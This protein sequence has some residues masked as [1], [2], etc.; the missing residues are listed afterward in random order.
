MT[1]RLPT[2][3]RPAPGSG[4]ATLHLPLPWVSAKADSV[5]SLRRL[6]SLSRAQAGSHRALVQMTITPHAEPIDELNCAGTAPEV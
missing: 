2:K 3:T 5:L 1:A 6:Q 4:P